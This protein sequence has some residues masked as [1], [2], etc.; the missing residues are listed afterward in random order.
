M[1]AG[2]RGRKRGKTQG[3]GNPVFFEICIFLAMDCNGPWTGSPSPLG[4]PLISSPAPCLHSHSY[5]PH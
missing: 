3:K 2:A 4:F 1:E 5:S